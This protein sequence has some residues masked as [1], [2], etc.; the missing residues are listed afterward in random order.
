MEIRKRHLLGAIA[1]A[2]AGARIATP[3][4][5]PWVTGEVENL[6]IRP[7]TAQ[8]VYSVQG[9]GEVP[10]SNRAVFRVATASLPAPSELPPLP[11]YL[12]Q[13]RSYHA[14]CAR[15]QGGLV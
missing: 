2:L 6:T 1:A 7:N 8:L 10:L 3:K 12:A 4:A 15:A 13:V 9:L 5:K 14:A 11:L